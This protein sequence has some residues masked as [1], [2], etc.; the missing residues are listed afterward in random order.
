MTS[1]YLPASDSLQ[2]TIL[3]RIFNKTTNSYKLLFFLALLDILESRNF[4]SQEPIGF[5]QVAIE[6]LANAWYPHAYFKL[7]FGVQ[8][9][10]SNKLDSLNL[11]FETFQNSNKANLKQSIANCSLD[12]IAN[13]RGLLRFVPFRLI[14]PFFENETRGMKDYDVDPTIAVLSKR[15]FNE[16]KPIY[17]FNSLNYQECDSLILHPEWVEYFRN[18][19]SIVR[20]WVSWEWLNY[21]QRR[22]PN[23]PAIANKLFPLQKRESLSHQMKY[24]K[25]IINNTEIK[26]IYTE[27]VLNREKLSLDHYLPWSFVT[28][29]RLWN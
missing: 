4:E 17:K 3:S 22:N 24:W 11:D 9:R 28:H 12:E 27:V 19:Y 29:D 26:C 13:D 16:R 10:I 18:N 2:I 5:R 15:S 14:R 21:M 6:M 23:T 25:T 8:D 20:G 7:S 1:D